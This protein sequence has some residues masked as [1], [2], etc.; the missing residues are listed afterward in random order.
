MLSVCPACD[1]GV[2]SKPILL[3][4]PYPCP[5]GGG[6]AAH[7]TWFSV[8]GSRRLMGQP[9]CLLLLFIPLS[10]DYHSTSVEYQRHA[11]SKTSSRG[12]FYL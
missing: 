5:L 3:D 6:Y 4:P 1:S 11:A 10:P 8:E 9:K 12:S 2:T 7:V